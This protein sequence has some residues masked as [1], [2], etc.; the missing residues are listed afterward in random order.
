M[1]DELLIARRQHLATFDD[2]RLKEA[3]SYSDCVLPIDFEIADL[4][5]EVL[6]ERGIEPD[7]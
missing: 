3:A 4:A 7:D 5:R 2:D 1:A 6:K